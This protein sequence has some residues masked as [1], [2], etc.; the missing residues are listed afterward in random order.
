MRTPA[1]TQRIDSLTRYRHAIGYHRLCVDLAVEP[2]AI[3]TEH[4]R[5]IERLRAAYLS[6]QGTPYIERTNR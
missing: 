4:E 3:I 1:E 2:P 6:L 5:A